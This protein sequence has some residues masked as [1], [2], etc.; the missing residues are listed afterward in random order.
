MCGSGNRSPPQALSCPSPPRV[1]SRILGGLSG[2]LNESTVS[3]SR[4]MIQLMENPL[5]TSSTY[6]EVPS[7]HR[8]FSNKYVNQDAGLFL[9]RVL[10]KLQDELQF[11]N[12]RVNLNQVLRPQT[13]NFLDL[14]DADQRLLLLAVAKPLSVTRDK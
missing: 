4:S 14:L 5:K 6:S 10:T 1:F 9:S 7:C 2:T 11:R 8:G 3:L 12:L 13:R